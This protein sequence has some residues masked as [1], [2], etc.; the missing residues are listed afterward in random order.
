MEGLM[1]RGGKMNE[2]GVKGGR[3]VTEEGRE[4]ETGGE[5]EACWRLDLQWKLWK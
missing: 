1:E 5:E 3:E 4:G 2:G